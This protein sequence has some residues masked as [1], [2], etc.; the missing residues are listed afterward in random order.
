MV[1]NGSLASLKISSRRL[2][3]SVFKKGF[4]SLG[5]RNSSLTQVSVGSSAVI[6]IRGGKARI[7]QP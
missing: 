6:Q 7:F 1:A 2:L 5:S 4:R 3:M